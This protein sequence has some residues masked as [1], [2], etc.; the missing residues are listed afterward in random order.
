MAERLKR[1]GVAILE[2]PA[3]YYDDL[4]ARYDLSDD[5]AAALHR[6]NI[7]YDRTSDGE[8]L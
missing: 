4:V 3:N 6:Y 1:A 2:I 8:F 5:F 7:L